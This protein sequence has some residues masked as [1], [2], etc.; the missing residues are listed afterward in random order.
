MFDLMFWGTIYRYINKCIHS[1]RKYSYYLFINPVSLLVHHSPICTTS[2]SGFFLGWTQTMQL[3]KCFWSYK[4]W[5]ALSLNSNSHTRNSPKKVLNCSSFCVLSFDFL[6][7]LTQP[8]PT[9]PPYFL[10]IAQAHRP[11]D[12]FQTTSFVNSFYEGPF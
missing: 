4:K 12:K 8:N 5:Q 10:W 7:T 3:L 9:P 11:Q 2:K 6:E 1:L